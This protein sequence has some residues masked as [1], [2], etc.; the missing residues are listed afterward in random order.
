MPC[1]FEFSYNF[2]TDLMLFIALIISTVEVQIK[3][4]SSKIRFA[5]I[6]SFGA[7]SKINFFGG[8]ISLITSG[9]KQ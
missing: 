4:Q 5:Q 7:H 3:R 9:Y 8:L 1:V 6:S 2:C